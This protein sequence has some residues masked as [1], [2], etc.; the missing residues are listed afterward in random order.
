VVAVSLKNAYDLNGGTIPEGAN[1]TSYTGGTESFTLLIPERDGYTF[2]GWTGTELAGA[3]VTVLIR[4]GSTG[5]RHYTATWIDENAPGYMHVDGISVEDFNLKALPRGDC[6]KATAVVDPENATNPG[7][8]WTSS[9]PSAVEV[10]ENGLI[11]AVGLGEDVTVTATPVAGGEQRTGRITVLEP[12]DVTGS[13]CAMDRT[14]AKLAVG[15][16]LRLYA[17]SSPNAVSVRWESKD[18]SVLTVDETGLVTAVGPGSAYV[19]AYMTPRGLGGEQSAHC[20]VRVVEATPQSIDPPDVSYPDVLEVAVRNEGAQLSATL[21]GAWYDADGRLLGVAVKAVTMS[22]KLS[23]FDL[24]RPAGT[25]GAASCRAFLLGADFEPLC[26]S[27]S[28]SLQSE[29]SSE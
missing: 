22:E 21:V 14:S 10:D 16:T 12:Q 2:A 29:P 9:D 6:W 3:T 20:R 26:L 8:L 28:A 18:T 24:A 23:F 7:V 13:T 11:R 25:S 15:E 1:P 27:K 4:R 19:F 5:D 17:N